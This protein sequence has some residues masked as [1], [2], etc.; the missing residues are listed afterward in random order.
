MARRILPTLLLSLTALLGLLPAV[1]ATPVT[2]RPLAGGPAAGR[3]G[4]QAPY[5]TTGEIGR[6]RA[7]A[8]D[9]ASSAAALESA[10][11]AARAELD[12]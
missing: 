6:A 5:P 1:Q 11:T 2:G 10:L 3:A 12:R 4:R 8:E 9:K 7:D